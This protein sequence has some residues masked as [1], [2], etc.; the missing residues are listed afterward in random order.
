MV[1]ITQ[2]RYP[3]VKINLNFCTAQ[4]ASDR[5]YKI[6]AARGL[7]LSDDWEGRERDFIDG[8]DLVIFKSMEDLNAKIDYYLNNPEEASRIRANGYKKSTEIQ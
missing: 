3:K 1:K 4:G 6:M 5:V 7:L 2:K 8:E